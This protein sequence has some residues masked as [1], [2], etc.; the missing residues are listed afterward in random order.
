M[1]L[2][3]KNVL[4]LQH[5]ASILPDHC[6]WLDK[7]EMD[8]MVGSNSM[9]GLVLSNG[10]RVIHVPSYLRGLYAACQEMGSIDWQITNQP[11]P[12]N[13]HNV[14]VWAGG[15]GM[16]QDKIMNT[17]LP[18]ALVRGASVELK[19]ETKEE[20]EGGTQPQV[21]QDCLISRL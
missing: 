1:A 11:P 5:A 18:V 16:I 20:E 7:H 4:D 3:D 19:V 17:P 9:G 15:A 14:V 13:D 12:V 2:S 10:C 8:K 6:E 21:G